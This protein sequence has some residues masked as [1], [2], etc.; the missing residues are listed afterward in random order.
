MEG[1]P[2]RPRRRVRAMHE[3]D[4]ER[5]REAAEMALAGVSDAFAWAPEGTPTWLACRALVLD[6][7]H[8]VE[9]LGPPSR[10]RR[11]DAW[12]TRPGRA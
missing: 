1:A 9:A 12:P 7:Q 5:E 11:E 4:A 3:H 6:F 8:R 10:R 2:R